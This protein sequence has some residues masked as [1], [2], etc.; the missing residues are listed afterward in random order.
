M[1]TISALLFE[2]LAHQ[3]VKMRTRL[4]SAAPPDRETFGDRF[5]VGSLSDDLLAVLEELAALKDKMYGEI[6]L[7]AD[8][9]F[10]SRRFRPSTA[11]LT[12]C[13]PN[14]LT[15]RLISRNCL[16]A[17]PYQPVLTC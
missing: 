3:Q 16:R 8:T 13:V 4:V 14:F 6:G 11:A 5:G 10:V 7:A 17:P 9:V 15:L 1:L 2:N 12:S